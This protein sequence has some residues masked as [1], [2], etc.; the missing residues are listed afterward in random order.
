MS[1]CEEIPRM[2]YLI[3]QHKQEQYPHE[4]RTNIGQDENNSLPVEFTFNTP[5]LQQK[6]RLHI[7]RKNNWKRIKKGYEKSVLIR[8][9]IW[10]KKK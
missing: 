2:E 9:A 6:K 1:S 7:N 5:N 8:H 10:P 4:K 3:W